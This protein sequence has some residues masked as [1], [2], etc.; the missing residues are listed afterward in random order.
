MQR[1]DPEVINQLNEI[2]AQKDEKRSQLIKKFQNDHPQQ[3]HLVEGLLDT[4][5]STSPPP[6]MPDIDDYQLIRS[7]GTGANGQ[8]YLAHHSDG[9][10]VAIKVPNVWLSSEQLHRF[11]HESELLKRLNHDSIAKIYSV[12]EFNVQNQK[13]PYIVM[14]YVDGIDIKTYCQEA[15]LSHQGCVE[16]MI[17]VLAAI[18]HAHQNRVIHR[19]LKPDNI[20]VDKEGV[21]K[22]ID[23]G[24][25]TLANDATR[26]MT[27]LT[28]TGEVVGTLSYMS[29]EQVSGAEAL[30]SRSDVYSCGVVL[31]EILV[32]QLPYQINPAQI[33]SAISAIIEQPIKPLSQHAVLVNESLA[34]VVHHAL[35]KE[36]NKRFQSANEFAND[37]GRWLNNEPVTS[38]ALSKF[39]W[40]KQAAK[41]NK[42]LVAGT[43]LAFTGLLLGLVFAVSFAIK[44][45]DARTLA[46]TRA[47]SNRQAI[48]F[49]NDLFENAD[50]GKSLGETITVKQVVSNADYA[51]DNTLAKEPQV[52]AQIRLI[53]GNVNFS[54]ERFAEADKHYDKALSLISESGDIY[55]DLITQKIKLLGATTKFEQQL[56]LI[57]QAKVTINSIENGDLLDQITIAQAA[58]FSVNNK[59][60][61]AIQ[62]LQ[63][64]LAKEGVEPAN[65][66]A[67]KKQL[68]RVY[69]E[70]GKFKQAHEVFAEL[71]K[72]GVALY[73]ELHPLT[74]D[75]RQ[76]LGLSL[77]YLNRLDEAVTIY[78]KVVEDAQK[79]FT[80][81]SLTTLLARVNLTV[82]Y[83]YQGDFEK[84]EKETADILPKMVKQLGSLHQYAMST[85]N[86]R[87]GALDNLGRVDEAIELYK[88]ALAAFAQSENKINPTAMSVQHNMAIAY[89]KKDDYE[90]AAQLYQDLIPKC[91]DQ[92]GKENHQCLIFADSM[93]AVE[94]ERGNLG[95]AQELLAYTTAALIEQFG[96]DHFRVKA[97]Q[98]RHQ[99]LA[100][101]KAE[102]LVN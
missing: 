65:V 42:A 86:I 101:K 15:G 68:G 84:A 8:V 45:K 94:I 14:E 90:M 73:G 7:I 56:K 46:D 78:L 99:K 24:I 20:I 47:E 31:Y 85:R 32:N 26:A 71:V 19:D 54:L 89:T 63:V 93:A 61:E 5:S 55:P 50:P 64:L 100:E 35:M 6:Q 96:D 11:K 88:E 59:L 97:S 49:I 2:I 95:A 23:F 4:E 98:E 1:I 81:E 27:Q 44:E 12:G 66:I 70:E 16:L 33:F 10:K 37:L 92:L 80:D 48:E 75:L 72:D 58:N 79:A 82:A 43:A 60:D 34:A 40:V 83:M 17:E 25:A 28:K 102:Q 51:V 76:E 87:A 9:S 91:I 53:L 41:N 67:A 30:D 21:P 18:Q 52:A 29:P 69:R 13:M 39:Y 57:D 62:M 77:R 74:I 38:Q 22:I 3:R 36:P